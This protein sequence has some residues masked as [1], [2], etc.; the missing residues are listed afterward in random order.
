MSTA[1]PASARTTSEDDTAGTSALGDPELRRFLLEYVK[2]R[3]PKA[4]ADDVVQTV[5]LDALAS[6]KRPEDPAELRKWVVGIARH[7]CADVHRRSGRERPADDDLPEQPAPPSPVEERALVRWAEE[8]AL[9]SRE[10]GKTLDWMAREGEGDKLEHIAEEEKLPPAR[11]RQRVSRMRRFLKERWLA[12]V[13]LVAAIGAL[14]FIVWRFLRKEDEPIIA[15]PTRPPEGPTRVPEEPT[16][17]DRERVAEGRRVREGALEVC[18]QG[19]DERCLEGLDRAREL[20]PQG[21][22]A[23]DVRDARERAAASLRQ[24][25]TP[26]PD[27]TDQKN[28]PAPKTSKLDGETKEPTKSAPP[29]K[30]APVE[31]SAPTPKAPP[32][33]RSKSSKE[34]I[35][36]DDGSTGN[37]D[38]PPAQTSEPRAAPAPS[39]LFFPPDS[40]EPRRKATPTK[41]GPTKGPSKPQAPTFT[42]PPSQVAPQQELQG[43]K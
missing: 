9:S 17:P 34:S 36:S 23:E 15:D 11:V 2:K 29:K 30:P 28:D 7:K 10:A 21:D 42:P 6:T 19:Q 41:S 13:A 22:A 32:T 3:V 8:Q 35:L 14:A 5:L 37:L 18:R 4:D 24:K 26:S 43:K 12:E 16:S 27:P 1:M 40:K 39:A 33:T 38:A 20:D 25:R 31:T